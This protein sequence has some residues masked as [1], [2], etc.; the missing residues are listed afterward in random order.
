MHICIYQHISHYTALQI[1]AHVFLQSGEA[2][3]A[4]A[5]LTEDGRHKSLCVSVRVCGIKRANGMQSLNV[6]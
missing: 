1:L 4:A 3:A 2:A 6:L 5:V